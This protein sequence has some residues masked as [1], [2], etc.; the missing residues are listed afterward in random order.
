M[1]PRI[2]TFDPLPWMDD[3]ACIDEDP[4]LFFP[5]G[6]GGT[7]A[8][9]RHVGEARA[10]CAK[11]SVRRTCLAYAITANVEGIWGGTTDNERRRVRRR[12]AR[13]TRKKAG[14]E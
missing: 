1:T 8:Y 6:N 9:D 10:V 11:C 2:L 12:E 14:S 3:A 5:V 13:N 4:E 7:A